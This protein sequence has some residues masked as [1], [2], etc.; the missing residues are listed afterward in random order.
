MTFVMDPKF[1][2][3]AKKRI[4]SFR[5]SLVEEL[6]K[7]GPPKEVYHLSV[8]IYPVTKKEKKQ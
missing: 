2:P 7:M 3:Y 1:I 5:R 8:Q 4:Q 6:E